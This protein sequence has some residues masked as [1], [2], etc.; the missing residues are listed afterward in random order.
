VVRIEVPETVTD[1][2]RRLWEELAKGSKFD[3]RS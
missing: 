1:D 3:P 2:E